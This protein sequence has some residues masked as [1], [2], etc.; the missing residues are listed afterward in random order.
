MLGSVAGLLLCCWAAALLL[1]VLFSRSGKLS[2]RDRVY[3][4]TRR[5]TDRP[6]TEHGAPALPRIVF[7]PSAPHAGE[8]LAMIEYARRLNWNPEAALAG[9]NAARGDTRA[10][11]LANG[12]MA[13]C[14]AATRNDG[15]WLLKADEFARQAHE[16]E[17]DCSSSPT[18]L[19]T[20]TLDG[21]AWG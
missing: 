11:A 3:S 10:M 5:M 14:V 9:V 18:L 8:K 20:Q 19:C 4:K 21:R 17:N 6:E 1:P 13:F 16:A 12:V 2:Q 7:D 15:T